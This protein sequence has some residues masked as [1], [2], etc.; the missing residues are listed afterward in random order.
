VS[1]SG[2]GDDEYQPDHQWIYADMSVRR[3]D[4]EH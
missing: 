1:L 3:T 4:V 2:H